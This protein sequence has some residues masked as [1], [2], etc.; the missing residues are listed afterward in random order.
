MLLTSAYASNLTPEQVGE[1]MNHVVSLAVDPP[2]AQ[3]HVEFP[4]TDFGPLGTVVSR[5]HDA[6]LDVHMLEFANG[7]KLNLKRTTFEADS[8]FLTARLDNGGRL[9]ETT[10]IPGLA[11]LAQGS[12]LNGGLGRLP[13]PEQ[14]Q[15]ALAGH[16]ASL[17]FHVQENTR[18]FGRS[19]DARELPLLLRLFTA[20]L[21]DSTVDDDGGHRRPIQ[22][23]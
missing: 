4:Y 13:P 9:R 22:S 12:L 21:T 5:R 23:A 8:V 14:L 7:V 10:G 16:F 11:S 20:F 1:H 19:A 17:N 2:S 3:E 15:G 6:P 18:H